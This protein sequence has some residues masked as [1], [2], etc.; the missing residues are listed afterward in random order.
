MAS[1]LPLSEQTVAA[2]I[3]RLPIS[4]WHVKMRIIVGT[5]TFFDA[6]DALA[7][8]FVLP[9]IIGPWKI[10]PHQIGALIAIGY[11]GQA[12]GALVFGWAAERYGRIPVSITTIAIL[13]VMSLVCATAASYD[14]LFWYRFVQGIGLGGEV[15]VAATYINEIARADRRGRFFILYEAAFPAG[16]LTVGLVGAWVVPR[17]GWQWMFYLGAIPAVLTLALRGLCPESP[18]WLA[19]KGRLNEADAILTRIESKV[20]RGGRVPLPPLPAVVGDATRRRAHWAELFQGR[21]LSRT[22]VVS[23][24]WICTYVVVYGVIVW[25]PTIFKTVYHLSVQQSLNHSLLTTSAGIVSLV[26]VAFIIDRL[27]RK[28]VFGTALLLGSLPLFALWLMNGGSA[29][30]VL[31]L[32][33]MGQLFISIL[34]GGL[35]LYTPE[36]Y[37]TRMRALGTGWATFWLRVASIAGPYIVGL[38]LPLYGL[39]GVFLLFAVVAALGGIICWV[40]APETAGRVL[41]EISP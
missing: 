34:A 38:I 9:A 23:A 26:V 3:E 20:S 41:E 13:A 35:Y 29:G 37:P 14:Q 15:P 33:A 30:N 25:L 10:A 40:G 28:R 24:L 21:Y 39:G 31:V 32:A 16:I 17:A 27:G 5:A 8:A 1:T 6:F 36:L 2:R 4:A 18:R 12:I 19:S 22:V 11:V 7:I